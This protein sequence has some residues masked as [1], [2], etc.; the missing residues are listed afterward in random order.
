MGGR[1]EEVEPGVDNTEIPG[2]FL[3]SS[4]V[5]RSKAPRLSRLHCRPSPRKG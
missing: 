5:P 1:K 2:R 3:M 4:E